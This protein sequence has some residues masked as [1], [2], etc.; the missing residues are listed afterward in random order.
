M[1]VMMYYYPKWETTIIHFV[2]WE[3]T[4]NGAIPERTIHHETVEP[5]QGVMTALN[6]M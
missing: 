6:L 1:L 4:M 5:S 2:T 3:V